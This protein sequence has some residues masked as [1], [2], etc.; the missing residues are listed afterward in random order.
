MATLQGTANADSLTGTAGAD[1]LTGLGGNDTLTGLGG[2][3]TL[4]G[5]AGADSLDGGTG[6]DWLSYAGSTAGVAVNLGTDAVSGG[7]AQGDTI[8]N[9]EHVEGSD[10]A[11]TL[12]VFVGA[13]HLRG[14]GGDD[15]L[16]DGGLGTDADTLEGG[17]GNDTLI[18]YAGGTPST[19]APGST[20]CPTRGRAR[21]CR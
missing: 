18:G 1:S 12:R 17:G 7:D 3:D 16:Q 6:N 9:F 8:A 5:G 13:N 4:N 2:A 10:H 21:R 15:W 14:G 19:A 20:S 11:D